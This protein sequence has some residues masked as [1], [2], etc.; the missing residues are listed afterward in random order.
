MHLEEDTLR[1]GEGEM[2]NTGY[3]VLIAAS[4]KL[5]IRRKSKEINFI[6]PVGKSR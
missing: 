5:E 3:I 1:T 2:S 6:L 4:F